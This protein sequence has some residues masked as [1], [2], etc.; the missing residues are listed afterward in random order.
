MLVEYSP[1]VVRHSRLTFAQIASIAFR[2]RAR[3][4]R[5]QP[6][7]VDAL[8]TVCKAT[9]LLRESLQA[10]RHHRLWNR[11]PRSGTGPSL[12]GQASILA[13]RMF[14]FHRAPETERE[15]FAFNFRSNSLRIVSGN[16]RSGPSKR[17][18]TASC[19]VRRSTMSERCRGSRTP[20]LLGFSVAAGRPGSGLG[21]SDY[22]PFA[23]ALG[24]GR[25][26]GLA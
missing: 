13:S 4:H 21:A 16:A 3:H 9:R 11:R 8:Y 15:P 1:K 19:A 18:S 12:L 17:Q 24:F 22:T 20:S 7:V 5:R 14:S 26:L 25:A 10:Q 23:P 2:G 6:L